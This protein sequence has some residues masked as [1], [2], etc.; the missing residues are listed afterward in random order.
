M[1]WQDWF[2]FQI[3]EDAFIPGF[4]APSFVFKAGSE[5]S[6]N[7]PLTLTFLS[8]SYKDPCDYMGPTWTIQ[9]KSPHLKSYNLIASAVSFTI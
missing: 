2:L 5:A 9:D 6:L 8:P 7:P 3:L 4:M 1:C